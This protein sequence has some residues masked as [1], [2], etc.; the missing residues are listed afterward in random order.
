MIYTRYFLHQFINKSLERNPYLLDVRETFCLK[1]SRVWEFKFIRRLVG[2]QLLVLFISK[3][4][5]KTQTKRVVSFYLC[6]SVSCFNLAASLKLLILF[7]RKV[8]ASSRCTKINCKIKFL[9]K[10]ASEAISFFT[11]NAISIIKRR[12]KAFVFHLN[13]TDKS[14]LLHLPSPYTNT[15][16][17]N[18][19]CSKYY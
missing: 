11:I 14:Y 5:P 6:F 16:S 19:P 3:C 1:V 2:G 10:R 8:P 9:F 18:H 4:R 12:K 7:G 15:Y 17:G 13:W